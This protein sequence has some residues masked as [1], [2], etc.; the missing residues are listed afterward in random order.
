MGT[1]TIFYILNHMPLNWVMAYCLLFASIVIPDACMRLMVKAEQQCQ[2][3]VYMM[4]DSLNL[5]FMLHLKVGC[6]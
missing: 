6:N 5:S 2:A 1:G 3:L 4:Q